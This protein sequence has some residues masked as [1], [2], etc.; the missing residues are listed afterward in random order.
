[1]NNLFKL[2]DLFSAKLADVELKKYRKKLDDDSTEALAEKALKDHQGDDVDLTYNNQHYGWFIWD[3]QKDKHEQKDM[4][5]F[6]GDDK[7]KDVREFVPKKKVKLEDY[8]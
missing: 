1:M 5:D 7:V 2:A 3:A 6:K 4:N 8:K